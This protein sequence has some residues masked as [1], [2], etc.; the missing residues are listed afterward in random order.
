MD[1]PGARFGTA[2]IHGAGG[3]P[4]PP[5]RS[6]AT[7]L[8][9][10]TAFT[11]PDARTGQE[12][13][14]GSGDYLYTR[15]GNPTVRALESRM[16]LLEVFP[17]TDPG[18]QPA[19]IDG[20]RAVDACF[21]ASGMAAIGAVALATC[22]GGKRL[23]AQE[24]IYGTSE[25]F[26]RGLDGFGIEVSFAPA[27]DLDALER[28]V[29]AGPLPALVY[30]ETPANPRLQLTDVA[31]AAG[32][33]HEAG[34]LLAVDA[35]FASPALLRPLRWG[36]D[37]SI[38]STTKFV[39]GHGVAIGGIVSGE[40]ARIADMIRPARTGLGGSPDPFAAWLT[41]LGLATLP[42]RMER[43][44]RTA[45]A[46]AQALRS[47]TAVQIV[48]YPDPAT[49]PAGQLAAGG[50]MLAFE[51]E[52]GETAARRVMDRL[53]VVTLAATLGT[54]DTL[55]QHP[56]SMS[57][58]VIPESRRRELGI[59]P[60]LLRVSVGLEDPEDLLEDFARALAD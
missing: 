22:A 3:D 13:F 20:P 33:A 37:F 30:V 60:G 1:R 38:H 25:T 23:V 55:I 46:L 52:G 17:V 42:V 35:T 43:H 49:L 7:P 14:R 53:E 2:A 54:L 16:A 36:A 51:V 4:E 39:S 48:H 10:S 27:G 28:S 44:C 8:F 50:A 59:R 6:H 19:G 47:E 31:A 18:G 32:I 34:A 5:P 24:G 58:V 26:L 56:A 45:A 29:R 40:E 9:Q 11:F 57:H 15:Q 12:A 41:L 21:F